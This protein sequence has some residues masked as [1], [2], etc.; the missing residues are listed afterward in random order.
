[1]SLGTGLGLGLPLFRFL[2]FRKGPLLRGA[3]LRVGLGFFLSALV[4]KL[5]VPARQIHAVI[6]PDAG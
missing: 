6:K 4:F 2:A 3:L 5:R 1:M